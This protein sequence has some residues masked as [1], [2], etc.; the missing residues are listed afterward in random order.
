MAGKRTNVEQMT[1]PAT[2]G[3]TK[4][5]GTAHDSEDDVSNYGDG[6]SDYFHE[7]DHVDEDDH[8]DHDDDHDDHVEGERLLRGSDHLLLL[9]LRLPHSP[10]LHLG[11]RQGYHH[12]H[13][14]HN[15]HYDH[16]HIITMVVIAP[17][18]G[19]A[20]IRKG[21]HLPSGKVNFT[22]N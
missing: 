11:L 19:G 16:Q 10:P 20:G 12:H 5:Y 21:R 6:D 14:H 13:H 8:D 18:E 17:F 3:F 4:A 22:T 9:R 2:N 1:G 15:H 7:Y